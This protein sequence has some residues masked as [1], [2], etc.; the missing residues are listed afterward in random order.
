MTGGTGYIGSAV[1]AALVEGGHDVVALVRSESS[2]DAVRAAGAAPVLG[3]MRDR[4]LV[5]QLAGDA[6]GAIHAAITNDETTADADRDLT[7]AVIAGL[8]ERNAPFVRTGGI[9]VH[10]SG[11]FDEQ[12]PLDAPALVAWRVAIDA[13]ALAAPGIRSILIEPGVVYGHG[14]GIPNVIT[15]AEPVGDPPAL[16]IVGDGTQHWGTVHVDDL[17]RLYVAALERA[18]AGSVFLG[19]NGHNPT[20][21]EIGEAASRVRGLGGRVV[22][23]GAEATVA[24]LGAFGEALLLDQRTTGAAARQA[25]G[26]SPS[27]PTLIE[28][29]EAGRYTD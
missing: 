15:R 3:D 8:G 6:D 14:K 2:A 10:G 23:E 1:L 9:W 4:D 7:E 12:T 22:A 20:V 5:A 19:V 16:P 29:I 26:W 25:L 11:D 24:K 17:A 18:E 21:R 13:S 28:E 27:S